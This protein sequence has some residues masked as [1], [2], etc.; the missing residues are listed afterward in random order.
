MKEPSHQ[1]V[2]GSAMRLASSA[3]NVR[4]SAPSI[5][6]TEIRVYAVQTTILLRQRGD[7]LHEGV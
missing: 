7:R 6:M 3:A 1:L 2:E 5:R 4:R